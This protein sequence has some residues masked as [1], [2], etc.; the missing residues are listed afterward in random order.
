VLSPKTKCIKGARAFGLPEQAEL[1]GHAPAC[2]TRSMRNKGFILRPA[3][4]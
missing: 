1:E 4:A 3:N 2:L